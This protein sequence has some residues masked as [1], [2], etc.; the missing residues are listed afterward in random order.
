MERVRKKKSN[1]NNK[2]FCSCL[3]LYSPALARRGDLVT[4]PRS[5]SLMVTTVERSMLDLGGEDGDTL[6]WGGIGGGGGTTGGL[7]VGGGG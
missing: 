6:A 2:N 7:V 5:L 4:V 1:E 3:P